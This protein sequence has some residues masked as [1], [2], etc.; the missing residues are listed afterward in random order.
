MAIGD[1]IKGILKKKEEPK[2]LEPLP[3]QNPLEVP[4]HEKPAVPVT[5]E[6]I[7]T[8]IDL[9]ISEIGSLKMRGETM[10]G[11]IAEIERMVRE[12]YD[13]AKRG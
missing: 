4:V 3:L 5:V 2:I 10:D 1:M 7:K 8:K 11:K 12:I 6:N 13:I 9:I